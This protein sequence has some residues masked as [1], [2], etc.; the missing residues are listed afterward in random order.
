MALGVFE[1]EYG[2]R[3]VRAGAGFGRGTSLTVLRPCIKASNQIPHYMSPRIG[4]L[5]TILD[6]LRPAPIREPVPAALPTYKVLRL[7]Q[8]LGVANH[9]FRPTGFQYFWQTRNC[10]NNRRAR[11]P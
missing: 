1:Y 3:G 4:K 9:P 10:S 2:D 7:N 11:K 8:S 6:K 5:K